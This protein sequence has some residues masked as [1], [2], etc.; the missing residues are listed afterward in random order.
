[1]QRRKELRFPVR[2]VEGTLKGPGD[3][4]VINVSR[5]GISFESSAELATG[6]DYYLELRYRGQKAN[7]AANLRWTA[8]LPSDHGELV[9]RGGG[10]FVETLTDQ[11]VWQTLLAESG[12]VDALVVEAAARSGAPA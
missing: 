9:F 11:G 10:P 4:Q 12:Q 1:M 3:V 2:G 7:V 6:H 5:R 8:C